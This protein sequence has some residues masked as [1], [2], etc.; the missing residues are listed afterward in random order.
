[1]RIGQKPRENQKLSEELISFLAKLAEAK[2]FP[3][4]T[5]KAIVSVAIMMF[6]ERWENVD[7]KSEKSVNVF[8]NEVDA[9]I[10]ELNKRKLIDVKHCRGF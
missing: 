10:M 3:L 9:L 7:Q 4:R 1:M 6:I 8:N 2:N 5:S